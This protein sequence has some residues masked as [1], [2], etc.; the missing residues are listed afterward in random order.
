MGEFLEPEFYVSAQN[1]FLETNLP[2]EVPSLQNFFLLVFF[3]YDFFSRR[4][5]TLLSK[6]C[7]EYPQRT[8]W[9][10]KIN[11]QQLNS[12]FIV[13]IDVFSRSK[14]VS[15][16]RKIA[17]SSVGFTIPQ[18]KVYLNEFFLLDPK[19]PLRS[20]V[21]DLFFFQFTYHPVYKTALVY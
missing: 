6:G 9:A 17:L 5:E 20:I 2:L 10:L 18:R 8:I 21:E 13:K 16:L 7:F 3:L 11:A 19:N 12:R 14:L 15:L 4:E 1:M